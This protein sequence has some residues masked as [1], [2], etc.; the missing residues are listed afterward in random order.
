M[1]FLILPSNQYYSLH[2]KL[3]YKPDPTNNPPKQ[4]QWAPSAV[5]GTPPKWLP[6]PPVLLCT[7][8]WH[9]CPQS[10]STE[11]AKLAH[12]SF[13]NRC[14]WALEP[15][16]PKAAPQTNSHTESHNRREK[17]ANTQNA[18]GGSGSSD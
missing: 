2:L 11:G 7:Y 14:S 16:S 15:N 18:P 17:T 4:I 8:G 1:P 13:H 10:D 12:E 9:Q 3:T 6:T 5:T